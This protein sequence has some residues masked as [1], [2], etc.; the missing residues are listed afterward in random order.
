MAGRKNGQLSIS[1][2]K[3]FYP[4]SNT[5]TEQRVAEAA[6]SR[7]TGRLNAQKKFGKY[8][9]MEPNAVRTAE[10][11]M[12]EALQRMLAAFQALQP[13]CFNYRAA[14]EAT[15]ADVWE[16]VAAVKEIYKRTEY[17]AKDV[18]HF[19]LLL[20]D[21]Q[22]IPEFPRRAGIFL[23]ILMNHGNAAFDYTVHT[24]HLEELDCLGYCNSNRI[25]VLGD[26][27]HSLGMRQT[28]IGSITVKGNCGYHPGHFM[29]GGSVI[30][31]GDAGEGIGR[32]LARGEVVIR[33]DAADAVGCLL[34]GGRIIVEGTSG[35]EVGLMAHGGE[36]VLKGKYGSYCRSSGATI[37][38]RHGRLLTT[39][40]PV[41]Q[42]LKGK[43]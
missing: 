34:Y 15:E 3:H 7:I 38:N 36:I 43:K 27:G 20:G 21:Y 39:A 26:G 31:D 30:V 8:K 22:D 11:E 37:Y 32:C 35:K 29:N 25:T 24:A 19:S 28:V 5:M 13:S 4:L 42:W 16:V 10:V 12:N 6:P 17:S 18:E 14:C 33:G 41:C 2:F 23:S 1:L 40:S 9:K